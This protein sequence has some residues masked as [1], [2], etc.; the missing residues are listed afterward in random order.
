M[1]GKGGGLDWVAEREKAIYTRPYFSPA[2]PYSPPDSCLDRDDT[3]KG[4]E[5]PRLTYCAGDEK[6]AGGNERGRQYRGDGWSKK[7]PPT[8]ERCNG[9]R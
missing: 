9:G 4:G 6:G 1:G 7:P 3:G 2:R 5:G 8:Q